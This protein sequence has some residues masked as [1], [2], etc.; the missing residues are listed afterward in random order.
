[1]TNIQKVNI[2][3]LTP[4]STTAGS[5]TS[6]DIIKDCNLCQVMQVDIQQ[7]AFSIEH[8]RKVKE[9]FAQTTA[10]AAT[11][12][13]SSVEESDSETYRVL[14]EDHQKIAQQKHQLALMMM[15]FQTQNLSNSTV[16][17]DLEENLIE[18][19]NPVERNDDNFSSRPNAKYQ[20]K[21]KRNSLKKKR[22]AVKNTSSITNNPA[23]PI[24]TAHETENELILNINV[25]RTDG[26]HFNTDD[27]DK[28]KGSRRS[29]LSNTIQNRNEQNDGNNNRNE[30]IDMHSGDEFVAL[31]SKSSNVINEENDMS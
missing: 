20:K 26:T 24:V 14:N 17:N 31:R 2:S 4:L 5:E 27:S 15:A 7:H 19:Q 10:A 22:Y 21:S 23:D 8:I 29:Y 18:S 6:N 1:M 12:L 25:N 3:G 11:L 30:G 28:I 9:I 16:F 13:N